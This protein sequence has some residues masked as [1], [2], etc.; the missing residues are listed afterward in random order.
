MSAILNF[1]EEKD[2]T[3]EQFAQSI[4][5]GQSL[6][7]QWIT[8]RRP[9]SINRALQIEKSHGINACLLNKKVSSLAKLLSNRHV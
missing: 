3:Q 2:M 8:G 5:V 4:G 7:S 1:L 9:I 6:V